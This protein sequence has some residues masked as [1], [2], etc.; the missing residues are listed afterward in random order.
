MIN[1]LISNGLYQYTLIENKLVCDSKSRNELTAKCFNSECQ[2]I[3]KSQQIFF[4]AKSSF[5]R[6]Q[7]TSVSVTSSVTIKMKFPEQVTQFLVTKYQ[8]P[9]TTL[10]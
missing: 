6:N 3:L 7:N 1:I 9:L 8:K 2:Q 10:F 4:L 5:S